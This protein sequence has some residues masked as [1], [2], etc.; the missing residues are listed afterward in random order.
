MPPSIERS[1]NTFIAPFWGRSAYG[2]LSIINQLSD[3]GCWSWLSAI[4]VLLDG[5]SGLLCP[6]VERVLQHAPLLSMPRGGT[7][8][9][10]NFR[11]F[12]NT[13]VV[14]L[15]LLFDWDDRFRRPWDGLAYRQQA[16]RFHTIIEHT[17]G[18]EHAAAFRLN[19]G[20]VA[21]R[22]LWIVPRFDGEHLCQSLK[23]T[24]HPSPSSSLSAAKMHPALMVA[25][26]S[27]ARAVL[28]VPAYLPR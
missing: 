9:S 3:E 12:E 1:L 10:T 11:P 6:I 2:N 13:W 7:F 26:I 17:I 21:A 27:L 14:R 18:P 22:F 24:S 25:I 5:I 16:R 19:S 28:F 8:R 23:I 15:Q 20:L 4:R